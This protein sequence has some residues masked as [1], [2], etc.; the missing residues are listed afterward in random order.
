MTVLWC[1]ISAHGFGHAAQLMPILNELGGAIEDLHVI[2]RTQV[3]ADFFQRHLRVRWELQDVQ[4]DVGCV[5][6]G[7]LHIDVEETWKAYTKFHAQWES[8]VEEEAQAIRL[9]KARLVI[10]NIS[11][12]A[13]AA[14]AQVKCPVVGIASLSWDRVLEPFAQADSGIHRSILETIR[15]SYGLADFLIRLHPGIEMPAFGSTVDVGPSAPLREPNGYDLRKA[16][17]VEEHELIVLIAF[18]GVPLNRLPLKQMSAMAGFHFLVSDLPSFSSYTSVHRV[19]DLAMPFGE[20]SQQADI[21][22]TK[23]GYGTVTAAVQDKTA[24][25][26]VRRHNF[27]DEQSLVEYIHRH[28]RGMELSRDDFESGNWEPTLR[29][30]L[31]V[32]VPSV[33][34]PSP[35]TGDVVHQLKTYLSC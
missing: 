32:A 1:S 17:G 7:P 12:L 6:R 21:I 33:A 9:S 29:A 11:P 31:K 23:P 2:L 15:N 34:H 3:P 10:S 28:G 27:I 13:I 20:I 5:Q 35:G 25:V 19:E 26:Y 14:A 16:L 30:V 22:M 24:L 4:Q 18:G 8:K